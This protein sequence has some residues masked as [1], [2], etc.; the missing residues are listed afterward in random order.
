MSTV[1][2]DA[3]RSTRYVALYPTQS[4][5]F[6]DLWYPVRHELRTGLWSC[7]CPAR[8]AECR[9]VIAAREF[10]KMRWWSVLIADMQPQHR[11]EFLAVL[12]S[13]LGSVYATDDDRI[14]WAALLAWRAGRRIAA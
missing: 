8:V 11:D 6:P 9:H 7:P 10:E 12:R 14:A 2:Y 13:R 4:S 5:R 3:D 1:R